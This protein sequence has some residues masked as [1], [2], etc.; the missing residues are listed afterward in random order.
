MG[1]LCAALMVFSTVLA[2]Q[3]AQDAGKPDQAPKLESDAIRAA[4][5]LQQ[6][7]V[8][9]ARAQNVLQREIDATSMQ[10]T[11]VIE[12]ARAV[13]AAVPGYELVLTQP[14]SCAKKA[15]EAPK[16]DESQ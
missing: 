4:M 5:E 3:G 10:L 6:Q 12:Q 11:R 7:I 8:G 15:P 2:A 13:C 16:K 9:L 1:R 14:L